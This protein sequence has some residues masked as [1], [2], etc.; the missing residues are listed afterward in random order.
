M[1]LSLC[2]AVVLALLPHHLGEV[3]GDASGVEPVLGTVVE[4]VVLDLIVP[5]GHGTRSTIITA[6][7]LKCQYWD[8]DGRMEDDVTRT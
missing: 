7:K 3:A 6:L 1:S 8:F 2:H 4:V 5:A